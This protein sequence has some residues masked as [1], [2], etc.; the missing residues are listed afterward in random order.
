MKHTY[1]VIVSFETYGHILTK[2]DIEKILEAGPN[3]IIFEV[4]SFKDTLDDPL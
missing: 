4:E 1:R 2:E 3:N